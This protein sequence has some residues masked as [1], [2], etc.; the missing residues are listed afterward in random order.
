MP[1]SLHTSPENFRQR[2]LI[3]LALTALIWIVFGQTL[4]HDFVGLDDPGYV[5]QNT[6][7][8]RGLTA[9]GFKA[10]FTQPHARNW[11]PLTTISHMLDC[12]LYGLEPGGHHLTN[13][14]LH[15]GAALLLFQV[16][17]AMTQTTW[18]SLFV[19]A[20]FAIH[21]L[22]AESVAWIAERK[23]VLSALLF[24]VALG[25]YVRYVRRPSTGRY[26]VAGVS[27]C[28]GLMAKSMLVTLPLLFLLL[29][30]WPLGRF[31]GAN[32]PRF[33][34]IVLEKVPFFAAAAGAAMAALLTQKATVEY[35]SALPFYWRASNSLSA[36]FVYAG[37]MLWPSR[38]SVFYPYPSKPL[39]IVAFILLST[40]LI[41]LTIGAYVLRRQRPWLLVGWLWYLI[42]LLPVIGLVQVGLQ[43]HADRYTYLPQIGLYLIVAWETAKM[44]RRHRFVRSGMTAAACAAVVLLSVAASRQVA[45]WKNTKTLWEHAVAVAPDNVLA[46]YSLAGVRMNEGAVDDAIIHYQQAIKFASLDAVEVGQP[47]VAFLHNSLG[48]ALMTEQRTDEAISEYRAATFFKPDLADAHMNLGGA[49]ASRNCLDDAAREYKIAQMIPPEDPESHVGLGVILMREGDAIA[50]L[51]QLERAVAIAPG[52]PSALKTLARALVSVPSPQLRDPQRGLL[53]AERAMR[54]SGNRDDDARRTAADARAELG[55]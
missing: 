30:Y 29:D 33:R 10:A 54:L 22:R 23:D 11:H 5:Y 51:A 36:V 1:A 47:H 20:L 46:Q 2:L 49:L 13:L 8:T 27:L 3:T 24:M 35:G 28:L 55:L 25:S 9:A 52:S 34:R 45:T 44:A 38:L 7:I 6:L 21:P 19:A 37:Q 18:R 31:K 15:T 26:L 4:G 40:A 48:N 43:A 41:S 32:A 39:N 14:L 12:Q 53:L 17:V 50:S 42:S 16:L